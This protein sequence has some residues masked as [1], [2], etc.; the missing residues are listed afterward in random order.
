MVDIAARLSLYSKLGKITAPK[1][2][3]DTTA[4]GDPEAHQGTKGDLYDK[5][6]SN[7]HHT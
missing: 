1:L 6:S 3:R 7:N 5:V 4:D 2:G